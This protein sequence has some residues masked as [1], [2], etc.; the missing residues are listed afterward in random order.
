MF[1]P[2]LLAFAF[3]EVARAA[4]PLD[5]GPLKKWLARQD[6]IRTVSADFTQTRTLRVLRDPVATPGRLWFSAPGLVRWEIGSPAKTVVLRK[7]DTTT[8]IT[9][10]K[11]RAERHTAGS[12]SGASSG[13][14]AMLRF[15]LAKDFADFQR[16]FEVLAIAPSA[17]RCRVEVAPRDAQARKFLTSMSIEFSQANGHL[18]AFE[19]KTRD[20]STM[21][22][23]FSNVRTNTRIPAAVFDYDLTGFEITDAKE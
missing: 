17:E 3:V 6:D 15:P 13:A 18:L 10:A 16:Q 2:A 12:S 21:R 7:G 22:Q 1:R 5:L 23:E 11:K 8:I 14:L 9:P 20:G 19:M 4:A